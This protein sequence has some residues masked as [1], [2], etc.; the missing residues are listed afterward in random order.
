VGRIVEVVE[1]KLNHFLLEFAAFSG[2]NLA[3]VIVE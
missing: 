1:T 3:L 2:E